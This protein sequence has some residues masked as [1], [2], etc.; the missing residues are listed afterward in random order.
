MENKTVETKNTAHAKTSN[1]WRGILFNICFI[2][3]YYLTYRW[4]VDEAQIINTYGLSSPILF[5]KTLG[6]IILISL[7]AEPFAVFYKLSYEN[8]HLKGAPLKLPKVFLVIMFIA[9]FFV[10]IV[11]FLAALESVGLE[12]EHG[13]AGAGLTGTFVFVAELVFIFAITDKEFTGKVKPTLIKQVLTAFVLLNMLAI[14]AFLFTP[15]FAAIL[16]DDSRS[17][18][19]KISI[20]LLL[21]IGIYLPNTMVQFYSDWRASQTSLQK[22][23]Y[24]LSFFIAYLS[25]ILFG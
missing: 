22:S 13:G 21:F 16:K 25:V 20:G 3:Y 2:L 10:R 24:I 5:P 19:W 23:L 11:F 18:L 1:G 9:R 14:F 6:W 12:V 17:A 15:F 7:I 4:V 8:Y